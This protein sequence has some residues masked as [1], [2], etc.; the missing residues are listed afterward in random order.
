[1]KN[2]PTSVILYLVTVLIYVAALVKSPSEYISIAFLPLIVMPIC[3]AM[4]LLPKDF[5]IHFYHIDH[6]NPAVILTA[7]W[8]A[9]VWGVGFA[10]ATLLFS[11]NSR[12]FL[13][14]LPLF[15]LIG[16]VIGA[17]SGS[18]VR[19]L[20]I[21]RLIQI[22]FSGTT[23]LGT[24]ILLKVTFTLTQIQLNAPLVMIGFAT[25]LFLGLLSMYVYTFSRKMAL[26]FLAGTV[27]VIVA[28]A[29]VHN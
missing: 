7:A 15:T 17:G 23:L 28:G 14:V 5:F 8:L 13:L 9:L 3:Y 18:I 27:V 16:Y 25:S 1:M 2:R 21:P 11:Q 19:M 26:S 10:S 29:V 12:L 22:M 20:G 24:A 4:L 6:S